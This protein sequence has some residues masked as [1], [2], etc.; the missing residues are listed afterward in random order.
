MDLR[1]K[2]LTLGNYWDDYQ[3]EDQFDD[4]GIGDDPYPIPPLDNQD[5]YPLME[6]WE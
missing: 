1:Y 5:N 6:P 4:D 3:G 2:C